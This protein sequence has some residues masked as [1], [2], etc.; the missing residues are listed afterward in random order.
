MG[1]NAPEFRLLDD[2]YPLRTGGPA[3]LNRGELA[4]LPTNSIRSRAGD[5]ARFLSLLSHWIP[6]KFG[7]QN[8]NENNNIYS[9]CNIASG[10]L[11][12]LLGVY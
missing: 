1:S 6:A 5:S 10:L 3:S 9:L 11:Q 12:R 7:R 4:F 8:A 2:R